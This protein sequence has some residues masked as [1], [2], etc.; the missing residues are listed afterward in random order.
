M[1][2]GTNGGDAEAEDRKKA[3]AATAATGLVPSQIA[4]APV[5]T[6]ANQN[7]DDNS[8][9]ATAKR[10]DDDV[11][12]GRTTSFMGLESSVCP[13]ESSIPDLTE[14]MTRF[15]S[16]DKCLPRRQHLQI[17][18]I[19]IPSDDATCGNDSSDGYGGDS[20]EIEL[21]YDAEWLAVLRKTHDLTQLTR[22]FVN[23]PAD[24]TPV[25]QEEIEEVRTRL[26]ERHRQRSESEDDGKEMGDSTKTAS[27]STNAT[28][29][30]A[31][32]VPDNFCITVPPHGSP[33]SD[34]APN[35]GAMVGN[36]QTDELLD[37]LGLEHVV[38]VPY[39]GSS[40]LR[41][42]PPTPPPHPIMQLTPDDNE[43]DLDD[44]DEDKEVDP[45]KQV[46][47]A[48]VVA[49][50][51]IDDNEI[52]LDDDDDEEEEDDDDNEEDIQTK[53]ARTG[54]IEK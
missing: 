17:V 36:P 23:V 24:I 6:T 50:P 10:R 38:T 53:K 41:G 22:S 25:T 47:E 32:I 8:E 46:T 14:Q 44:D 4:G 49:K 15:L 29:R 51:K 54:S 3:A 11:G 37:L 33:G 48:V 31:L 9:Q 1:R 34:F 13:S 26:I 20:S 39:T 12:D 52:D 5:T 35:G 42:R 40:N 28:E 27:D 2:H 7:D 21:E 19:P 45:D 43:I 18:N 30:S 16:L